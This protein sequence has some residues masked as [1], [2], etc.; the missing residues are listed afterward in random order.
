[1]HNYRRNSS[2]LCKTLFLCGA[3]LFL[4][5][6]HLWEAYLA[7][8]WEVLE[9]SMKKCGYCGKE[10]DESFETTLDNGCPAC[11]KCVEEE[12]QKEQ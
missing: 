3:A 4:V 5:G 9:M 12:E 2:S 1:M 10:Y 6:F 11:P 7:C 8:S